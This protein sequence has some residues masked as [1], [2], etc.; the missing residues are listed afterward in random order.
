VGSVEAELVLDDGSGVWP[1]GVSILHLL[2]DHE[3]ML[4]DIGDQSR[5]VE[6]VDVD[7][8]L[9][10]CVEVDDALLQHVLSDL[11]EDANVVVLG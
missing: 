3:A 8:Q 2:F 5:R 4:V 6:G 11:E 7:D 10:L 9:H 1:I